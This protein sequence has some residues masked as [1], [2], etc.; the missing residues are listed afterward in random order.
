MKQIRVKSHY[1]EV[2]TTI[3]AGF[4]VFLESIDCNAWT[5]RV[6]WNPKREVNP[7]WILKVT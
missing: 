6:C 7:N 1:L 3:S 4:R 2:L 5:A